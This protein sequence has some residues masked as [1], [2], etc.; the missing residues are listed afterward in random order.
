MRLRKITGVFLILMSFLVFNT[1]KVEAALISTKQEISMGQS[2]A[3]QLEDKYG[4]VDDKALQDRISE[5]GMRMVKI[6]DRPDLPYTFKVLNSDEVNAVA[7]PGG[8]IYVYKGLTDLMKSDDELAG[9][10]GHELGHIVERHSVHQMEKTLGMTLLFGGIFKDNS[11]ALQ[12]LAL[13]AIMA[14]YSRTDEK[15]ADHLGFVHSTKAG[16]NPYGML[17]GLMKL[18]NLNPDQKNTWFSTHPEGKTRIELAKKDLADA[19]IRPG[20]IQNGDEIN[21]V[22][23]NWK[24]PTI[25]TAAGGVEAIYRAYISAGRIYQASLDSQYNSNKYILDS[26]GVNLIIYYDNQIIMTVSDEDANAYGMDVYQTANMYINS[27]KM[28]GK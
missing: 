13:N 5:I 22:D 18:S 12:S 19:G 10:I 28:W 25:K 3:K 21:V 8:F 1:P 15:E 7:V 23:K 17:I 9:V 20:V 14:G 24:L 2:V 6:C 16:Y 26:D 27:L 11:V 4:L